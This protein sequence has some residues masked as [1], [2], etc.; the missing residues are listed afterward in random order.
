MEI[1]NHVERLPVSQ[2]YEHTYKK[3]G[4]TPKASVVTG[5][6]LMTI[7]GLFL[8]YWAK[9]LTAPFLHLV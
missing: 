1:E 4:F 9:N 5:L 7:N 2:V 3:K 8:I 6:F